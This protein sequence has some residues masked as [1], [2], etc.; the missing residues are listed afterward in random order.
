MPE[1]GVFG[2]L[3]RV[4]DVIYKLAWSNVLWFFTGGFPVVFLI[5]PVF[6]Q[7]GWFIP[8]ALFLL[9]GAPATAALFHVM[10]VWQ[11]DEDVS[12]WKEYWRGWRE[13]WKRAYKVIDI[14][15]LIGAILVIDLIVV[16]NAQ[17]SVLKWTGLLLLPAL[18]LYILT[19]VTLLPLLVRFQWK[20]TEL[21]KNAFIMSV[22]HL[23][24]S[25][26]VLIGLAAAI[27]A[28]LQ[29]MLPLAFFF[30]GSLTAWAFTWQT[31]RIIRKIKRMEEERNN[32]PSQELE[33]SAS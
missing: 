4:T 26:A 27:A 23:F 9:I 2:F 10:R 24:S 17:Q 30:F 13:N 31:N 20:F 22:S 3:Y 8:L 1:S 12:V 29:M 11:D 16:A 5:L 25:L 19:S 21:I 28:A 32:E 15:V 33:G 6:F 14:Y 7:I 18:T